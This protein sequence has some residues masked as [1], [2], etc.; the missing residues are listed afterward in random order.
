MKL[1]KK[2]HDDW[3]TP[4]WFL[5]Y[6]RKKYF[7]GNDFFDPCP[8]HATFDGLKISWGKY[9]FVN[10]PYSREL[11]EAFIIKAFYEALKG[12]HVILLLPVS[13]S[14][15]IFHSIIQ[16]YGNIEFVFKRIKFKGL[17]SKGIMVDNRTGQH[18]SMIVEFKFD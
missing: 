5:D 17:N 2:M 14:T 9:T 10:P 4:K 1:R 8:L 15:V 6:I 7:N 11:K 13:T 16:P 18:D 3:S 12:C